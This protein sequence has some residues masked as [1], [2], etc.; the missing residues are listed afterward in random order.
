M[1]TAPL[2]IHPISLKWFDMTDYWVWHSKSAIHL[3]RLAAL[4]PTTLLVMHGSS[5]TGAGCTDMIRQLSQLRA[6]LEAPTAPVAATP[7][8]PGTAQLAAA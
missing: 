5:F 3:E 7:A 4:Q 1:L 6:E 2:P 8:T